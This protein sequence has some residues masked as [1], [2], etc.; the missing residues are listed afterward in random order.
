MNQQQLIE[1][2]KKT[3]FYKWLRHNLYETKISDYHQTILDNAKASDYIIELIQNDKPFMVS[4]LGSIELKVL[5]T[6]YKKRKYTNKLRYSIKNNAGVFPTD[7]NTLD[8]FAKLYFKSSSNIDLLGIWFN[9]FEDVVANKFCPNAQLTELRNLEPYF[10]SNP[11]SYYLKGKKVLVIHPFTKSIHAQYKKR[12]KLFQDKNILPEFNLITLPA[13]QSLGGNSEFETWFNA[14]DYMQNEIK[15]T[16][17]DI[18][19]IGAG[20]YGLPL[21]SYIK[22]I[23][24]KS[25]HLGG[26]TQMLFGIYGRRWKIDPGFQ[27][28]INDNWIKPLESEKPPNA[29]LVENAC[30]W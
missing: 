2:L 22:D 23:G 27:H 11:W 20:A 26:S 29:A 7:N 1:S 21:A 14:L 28:L 4:R 25:I 5:K 10:S 17:F 19:I 9:P 15:K 8:E 12:V 13:I 3:Y 18:A 6:F 24:K 30:Y 16:D